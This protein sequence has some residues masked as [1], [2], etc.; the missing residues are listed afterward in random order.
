MACRSYQKVNGR[1]DINE[2]GEM[3]ENGIKK[4]IQNGY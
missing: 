4:D 1:Q 3:Q 2:K